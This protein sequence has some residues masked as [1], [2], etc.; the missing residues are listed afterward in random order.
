MS[1]IVVLQV[2]NSLGVLNDGRGVGSD[3]ELDGL[4]K[5][6]LAQKGTGLRTTEL[7]LA[8]STGN[9]QETTVLGIVGD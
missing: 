3:K 4:G 2:Q 5:T 8:V 9:S 6:V 1:D 7:G